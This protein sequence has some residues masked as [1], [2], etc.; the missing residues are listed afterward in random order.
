MSH[1]PQKSLLASLAEPDFVMTDF[2]KYS[3]PAQ[4]H[5][6]FQAL[7]QFC[8]QHGRPPR[9]RNEVGE[10]VGQPGPVTYVC[11]YLS[12]LPS[13]CIPPNPSS[14][15]GLTEV[16]LVFPAPPG[17][18]NRAGGLGTGRECSSPASSAA[19]QPG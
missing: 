13:F 7:H 2:A 15:S 14:H 18:C 3:R 11:L 12:A 5:L 4:L 6:G 16:F 8:A 10:W 1:P 9:P 19:G 17:R